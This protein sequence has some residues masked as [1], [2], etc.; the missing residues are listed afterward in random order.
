MTRASAS[1][2]RYTP[3]PVGKVRTFSD[4]NGAVISRGKATSSELVGLESAA[5]IVQIVNECRILAT[6]AQHQME[7]NLAILDTIRGGGVG[8]MSCDALCTAHFGYHFG[9]DLR[10]RIHVVND[11][12]GGRIGGSCRAGR[13]G[14]IGNA[15]PP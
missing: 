8:R 9:S 10:R 12:S 4:G 15:A 14:N 11:S 13:I 6:K 1:F 2:I 3:G 5:V 7:L